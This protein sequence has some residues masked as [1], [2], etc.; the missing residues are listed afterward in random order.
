[1][2]GWRTVGLAL[3]LAHVL[4]VLAIVL[5]AVPRDHSFGPNTALI[6]Y[7][8]FAGAWLTAIGISFLSSATQ[9]IRRSGV[10]SSVVRGATELA[11]IFTLVAMI[12]GI[13]VRYFRWREGIQEWFHDYR[14]GLWITAAVLYGSLALVSRT[15]LCRSRLFPVFVLATPVLAFLA[16]RY[17]PFAGWVLPLGRRDFFTQVGYTTLNAAAWIGV[18]LAIVAVVVRSRLNYLNEKLRNATPERQRSPS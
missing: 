10:T 8:S 16:Y 6:L 18:P 4:G 11:A 5:F 13:F 17:Y 3:A 2:R 7:I 12:G 9:L 1:M 15:K 14:T